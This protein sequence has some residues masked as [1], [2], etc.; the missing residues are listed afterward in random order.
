[1]LE[2]QEAVLGAG[3]YGVFL[4]GV[5][6]GVA[7]LGEPLQHESSPMHNAN[8]LEFQQHHRQQQRER[9]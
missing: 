5:R 1:M 6:G 7:Q 4:A 2:A 9:Q 8:I 3:A